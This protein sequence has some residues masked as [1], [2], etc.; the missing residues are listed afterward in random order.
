MSPVHVGEHTRQLRLGMLVCAL[1]TKSGFSRA[2]SPRPS[3]VMSHHL[4]GRWSAPPWLSGAPSACF[5]PSLSP[6][7]RSWCTPMPVRRSPACGRRARPRPCGMWMGGDTRA[8][9]VQHGAMGPQQD[10][11]HRRGGGNVCPRSG[12]GGHP[13]VGGRG[14]WAQVR[15]RDHDCRCH[16]PLAGEYR[17][18]T[19]TCGGRHRPRAVL[20]ASTK[21]RPDSSGRQ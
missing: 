20:T 6:P 9:P 18:R 15:R 17:C 5:S 1:A 10:I 12:R 16:P 14:A 8:Q 19:R 3:P 21:V 4:L 2:S 7:L 11:S 13:E